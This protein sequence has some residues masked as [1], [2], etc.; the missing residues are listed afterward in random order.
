MQLDKWHISIN[1]GS[2]LNDIVHHF[3]AT[4]NR[5]IRKLLKFPLK[6]LGEAEK[7]V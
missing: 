4:A 5:K 3:S 2:S 7:A 6:V 1:L